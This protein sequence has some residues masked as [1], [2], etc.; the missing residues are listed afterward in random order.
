MKKLIVSFLLVNAMAACLGAADA[1]DPAGYRR[2]KVSDY[3]DKMQAGWIGPMVGSRFTAE[4][5]AQITVP[6]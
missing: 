5:M 1:N 6:Q 4:E 3:V 2:I